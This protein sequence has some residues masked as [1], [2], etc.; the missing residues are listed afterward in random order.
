VED[1]FETKRSNHQNFFFNPSTIQAT[2]NVLLS[3]NAKI[4]PIF[5]ASTNFVNSMERDLF[6]MLDIPL[7]HAWLPNKPEIISLVGN[8]SYSQLQQELVDITY[9]GLDENLPR[10]E[11]LD[12][13]SN[14]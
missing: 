1:V 5:T 2:I 10:M 12:F 14:L 13:F 11:K 7:Y 6:T 3:K 9:F 4:D 8:S